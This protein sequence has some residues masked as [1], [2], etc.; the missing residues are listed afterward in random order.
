MA[1]I[2]NKVTLVFDI[3]LIL[4]QVQ[5]RSIYTGSRIKDNAGLSQL[6]ETGITDSELDIA[7]ISLRDAAHELYEKLQAFTRKSGT[8]FIYDTL[9]SLT[10]KR[11]ILYEL[12]LPD[13]WDKTHTP[14]L[15][16]ACEKYMVSYCLLDWFKTIGL[17]DAAQIKSMDLDTHEG[18]IKSILN[19]RKEKVRRPYNTI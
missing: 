10:Q 13:T 6:A 12:W 14:G 3:A 17:T 4:K 5:L 15:T 18:N 19:Y 1:E 7:S 11:N 8:P 9:N 16:I 2:F